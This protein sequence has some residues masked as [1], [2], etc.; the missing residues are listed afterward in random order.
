MNRTVIVDLF[1]EDKAHE[2]F[3]KPAIKRFAG[4]LGIEVNI[5]VR[6]ARGGHGKAISEYSLY[7]EILE[8]N[9]LKMEN[10]DII[11]VAI[12][13]NCK[14]YNSM[15][16][17][18]SASVSERQ[19]ERTVFSCPDPHIERWYLADTNAIQKII[20]IT[21]KLPRKKCERD[22]YK[23]ILAETIIKAGH[24]PSLGGIEFA[25]EIVNTMDFYHAGKTENSLNLFVKDLTAAMKRAVG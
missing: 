19:R 6:S 14:G 16:R 7:R 17:E 25:E 21:V 1:A 11:V 12:D 10:P 22:F 13:C 18:I 20:G 24:P 23:K 8:K 9:L 15:V 2:E 4:Q 3:I 5:R